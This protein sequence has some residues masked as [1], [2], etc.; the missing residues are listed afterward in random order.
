MQLGA[1]RPQLFHLASTHRADIGDDPVSILPRLDLGSFF[2]EVDGCTVGQLDHD[3]DIG[4]RPHHDLPNTPGQFLEP[5]PLHRADGDGVGMVA[6]PGQQTRAVGQLVDLVEHHQP[7]LPGRIDRIER[8]ID[9]ISL[10]SGVGVRHVDEDQQQLTMDRLLQRRAERGHQVMGKIA[11]ESDGIRQQRGIASSD[12]PSL[13]PR[14]ERREQLVV[15]EGAA[16]GQCIEQRRL[17]GIG[18]AH[19]PHGEVAFVA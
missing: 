12:F 5:L 7:R 8:L 11:Y 1:S 16:G 15:G 17:A 14:R 10:Q 9:R 13:N 6:K 2:N 3:A 19:E 4:R 18:V